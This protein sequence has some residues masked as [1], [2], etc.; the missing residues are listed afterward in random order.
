MPV[1]ASLARRL[2]GKKWFAVVGRAYV[3]LDRLLSRVSKGR[4]VALGLRDLPSLLLTTTG[5]K[6]GQA[7]QTPLLYAP[8]GDAFVVIG[9][10]W[11]QAHHPAWSANLIANPAAT[12][13]LDGAEIPVH[14]R[15]VKGAERERLRELLLRTWPAYSAYEQRAEGRHLRIFRLE[16]TG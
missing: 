6:S 16:R 2:G 13:L 9:S 14:G 1:L 12:V 7:R 15:L 4:L 3:P 5:R 8:D 11:G 10:N